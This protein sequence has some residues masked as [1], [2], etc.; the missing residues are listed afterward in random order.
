VTWE[1]EIVDER[2][3][4]LIA[5]RSIEGSDVRN[6]GTVRFK[7]APGARGTEI[8]VHL[9]YQPP[10]GT[11][12]R[13]VAWLFGEAPEQQIREDLRRFKQLME[14][15]EIPLSDGPGLWRPARPS[16]T[17]EEARKFSGVKI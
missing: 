10:A 12:G 17:P 13:G 16:S 8:Q 3:N 5:W 2:E 1:A 14:T 6:S 15:G 9:D 4:E 7:R 11:L